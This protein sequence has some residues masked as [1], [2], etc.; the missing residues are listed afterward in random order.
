MTVHYI[1][2]IVI[3]IELFSPEGLLGDKLI[4]SEARTVRYACWL[5]CLISFYSGNFFLKNCTYLAASTGTTF[6]FRG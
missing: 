5:S 6:L 3:L 4:C 1:V 2:M